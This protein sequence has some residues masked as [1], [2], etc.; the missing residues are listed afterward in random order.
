[1]N[2]SNHKL[3]VLITS[4][5]LEAKGGIVALHQ[6]LFGQPVRQ[7]FDFILFPV[8]SPMP[9][10]EHLFSRFYRVINHIQSICKLLV[11]DKSIK[12]IHINSSYDSKGILRDSLFIIIS[13]LFRKKIV[14]QIHSSINSHQSP[15]IVDRIARFDF[16]LCDKVLIYSVEDKK[17]IE[18]MIAEEKIEIFPNAIRVDDFT[19]EDKTYK[20]DLSIP[21]EGKIVLFVSRLIEDKGVYDLIDSIPKVL[22][23]Y[24]NVFFLFAGDGP[25]KEGMKSS[26]KEKGIEK[27]VRFT[28]H[29]GNKNLIKAF[30]C[31]DIFV[32]PTYHAEG[33]P[34]VI[35]QALATGLPIISTRFGAIPDII[36][37]GINGFLIE[38]HAPEQISERILFL[39]RKEGLKSRMK[40]E[41]I[42]LAKKEFDTEIVLNKL[43]QVYLSLLHLS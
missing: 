19:H 33:M 28:G 32:L 18:N 14:L 11:K 40:K 9:F 10:R 38:P 20:N 5:P 25:E 35:L 36:K 41:N 43:E 3:N 12:I 42:Q 27:A 39:L 4:V 1:M 21:D 7:S 34:M 8:S 30:T 29:I 16:N 15:N 22:E 6:V 2:S 31:A 26:C 17:K 13:F 37:D 23:E 24:N